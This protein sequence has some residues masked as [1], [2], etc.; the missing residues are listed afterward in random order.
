MAYTEEKEAGEPAKKDDLAESRKYLQECIEEEDQERAKMKDDLRFCTLDQWPADIRSEREN[1]VENGPRPCLTIDKVNQ[2][3]VQV[4]N[5]IRQGRPG[6][7]V[8]PQ[9]NSGDI[10]TAKLIKGV[11]RN[12][13]DQSKADIAYYVAAESVMRIGLGYFRITTEY[14]DDESDDQEI[15]IRPIPNTF[16]VY[17]GKHIMPDGSD[18]ERGYIVESVPIAKFKE[19]FPGKKCT[20]AEFDGIDKAEMGYWITGETITVVEEYCIKRTRDELHVLDDGTTMRAS[21]YAKWPAEAGPKP[22]ILKTRPTFLRQLQWKKMTGAEVLDSRDLPGQYI[23]IVEMVGREAWVDGRRILWGLVR[24]SKDSLRM[25]NYFASTI[26]ERMGLAPKI[27]FIGAKGQFEGLEQIW[28]KANRV[29]RPYLEYNPIDV[30]GNA[31]PAPQRVGPTPIEAALLQ[32][33][34]VI[35]HDVQTSLGMFKAA[36]GESES[37]QSGRAILALQRESDT[38]TYHFGANLGMSIRHAGRIIVDLIPHYYDTKRIVRILG[39]DGSVQTATL[40]PDMEVPYQ[41][42]GN[43]MVMFNPGLGKYD[44]SIS[45]GPSYNTKRMEAQATFVELAKGAADPVSAM[46]LRYLTTL[47]SDFEGADMAA[48]GFRALL[49][50]PVVQAMSGDQQMDPVAQAVV[51][52]AQQQVQAL[53]QE[54]QAEQAGTKQAQMKIQADHDAKMKQLELDRQVEA[55]KAKLARE[56]AEAE[57]KLKKFQ[58]EQEM[59]LADMQA[60]AEHQREEKRMAMEQD[61]HMRE[62]ENERME[63]SKDEQ[64]EV[65]PQFAQ[66]MQQ[67]MTMFAQALAQQQEANL[68]GLALIAEAIKNPAPRQVTLGGIKRSEAGITQATATIQ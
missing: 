22:K 37:Q 20:T 59:E 13:E 62:A 55:E 17:L 53:S 15:F 26:T 1:D 3:I 27:P 43:G 28:S 9:D 33:M 61:K 51:A 56:K 50:P 31:L 40:D 19:E 8:R 29:N 30:N 18:A 45:T 4:L 7:N 2:Y 68:K 5:D 52:Q 14:V 49:P 67:M 64:A 66:T 58:C 21:M 60:G 39:E 11:V 41:K 34:Q 65:A 42:A 10:E 48:K 47:N 23:P 12:I 24:P 63:R 35:E 38:G 16:S 25:Y 57:F 46:L 36:T 54:L 32:Q 44:V 6:I